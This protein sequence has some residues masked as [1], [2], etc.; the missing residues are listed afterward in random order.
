MRRKT[1]DVS[2]VRSAKKLGSKSVAETV[3]RVKTPREGAPNVPQAN[4]GAVLMVSPKAA[5]Q[6]MLGSRNTLAIL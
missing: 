5:K 1:R 4:E 3:R 2:E 6:A